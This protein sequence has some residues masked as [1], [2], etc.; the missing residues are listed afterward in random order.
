MSDVYRRYATH[1]GM[2]GI[3]HRVEVERTARHLRKVLLPAL[4]GAGLGLP[5]A[6]V[7]EFGAGWGRNLLALR[8]L[9]AVDLSGFDAS[10]E[11]VALAHRF[12]VPDVELVRQDAVPLSGVPDAS[13][14]LLLAMDVLEHLSL[15]DIEGFTGAA[16]RVLRP[17]GLLVVQVP[18]AIAP[19][20]PVPA[21]DITHLRFF[22][23]GSVAQLLRMCGLTPVLLR[24]VP[25][26]SGGPGSRVRNVL[27][28]WLVAPLLRGLARLLH[29]SR[30]EPWIVS[31]NILAVGRKPAP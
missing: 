28:D 18:N 4:A 15:P 12:G 7:V 10:D 27:A 11:Q 20:N 14:D 26:P 29:G 1:A 8:E 16:N 13:V 21:G 2:A 6:R 19:L 22:N 30:E 17:G 24:G 25:F 9:G 3:D 31:P 5:G 23:A